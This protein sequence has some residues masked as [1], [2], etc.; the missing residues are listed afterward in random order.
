[1]TNG[2][3]KKRGGESIITGFVLMSAAVITF[4]IAPQYLGESI[5]VGLLGLVLMIVG[6]VLVSGSSAS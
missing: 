1:M 3:N 2:K 4:L 6:C 5:L